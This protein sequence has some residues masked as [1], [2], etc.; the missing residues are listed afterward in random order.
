[1]SNLDP[2]FYDIAVQVI[3]G[4]TNDDVTSE[5]AV[6]RLD[7]VNEAAGDLM[8]GLGNT[9]S[10]L[11]GVLVGTAALE[12]AKAGLGTSP[13][14][15]VLDLLAI[16]L[17]CLLGAFLPAIQKNSYKLTGSENSGIL[18]AAAQVFI[19][20]TVVLSGFPVCSGGP[21]STAWTVA[22]FWISLSLLVFSC[23]VMIW[24]LVVG[25]RFGRSRLNKMVS[26]ALAPVTKSVQQALPPAVRAADSFVPAY[27]LSG[28]RR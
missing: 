2:L 28:I 26:E 8:A 19:L 13:E 3:A 18:A 6:E 16:V 9:F 15:W 7:D 23:S 27:P 4:Q 21:D 14:F 25:L 5:D 11:L 12:I 10:D 20:G 24:L 1:M 22:P 17:G